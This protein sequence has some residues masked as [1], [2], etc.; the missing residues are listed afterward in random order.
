MV[1]IRAFCCH[2]LFSLVVRRI[3]LKLKTFFTCTCT[4]WSFLYFHN[5]YVWL[6]SETLRCLHCFMTSSYLACWLIWL[7]HC[8]GIAGV[9]VWILAS[10]NFFQVFFL[11]LDK[12]C[13]HLPLFSLHVFVSLDVIHVRVK[14]AKP[15]SFVIYMYL[16]H[17]SK[18]T[19]G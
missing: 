15:Q 7:E 9:M 4:W 10:L 12:L 8:T 17:R 5:L 13:L 11:H 14:Q 2:M 1:W 3:C 18:L 16:C 19:S 6:S